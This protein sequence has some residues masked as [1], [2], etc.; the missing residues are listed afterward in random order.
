M[1]IDL[2]TDKVVGYISNTLG[3][4]GIAVAPELNRGFT[5][6]VKLIP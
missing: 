6:M 1:V 3:V 5:V 2:D 4:H